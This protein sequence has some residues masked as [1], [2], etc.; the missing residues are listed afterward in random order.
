LILA[1]HAESEY[2]SLGLLNGDPNVVVGLTA[3]GREEART[4]GEALDGMPPD[5]VVI[6]EFA[7]TR[8]TAELACPDAPRLV[9]PELNDPRYGRFEGGRLE[10]FRAWAST[11]PSTAVPGPGGESRLTIVERYARGFRTLLARPEEAILVVCHSL[12]VSYAL[13]A[14]EGRAPGARMPLV[15]YATPY[16]FTH[17]ELD[18]AAT[19][20][21]LWSAQPTW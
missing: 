20:L 11:H 12:P 4:L 17:E 18:A 2:S 6:T 8:E 15:E 14:R 10:D 21:E 3:R 7:R 1:R 5:L 13:G 19:L 16:P 9:V